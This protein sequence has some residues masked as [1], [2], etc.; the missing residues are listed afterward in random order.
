[1]SGRPASREPGRLEDERHARGG[2]VREQL[3]RTRRAPMWPSPMRLVPVLEGAAHV[4]R[5]VGVDQPQPARAADLD[6]PVDGRGR[7]RRARRAARRRRRRGRCPGRCRPGV[8]VEGGEV[9]LQV[10]DAGA[11]RAALPGGRLQQQP[12]RGVVARPRRAPAAA[13]R[14]PGASRRRTGPSRRRGR[15][16][17]RCARPRPRRR[18]RRRGAG[19]GRPSATDFSYVAAVG[20]AEVHQVRR[21]D[22]H[23]DAALGAGVAGTRA[24]SR[25]SPGR[26]AP[27]RGGCR[28]RP[29]A[30]RSRSRRRV[31]SAPATSPLPTMTWVPTGLR[32]PGRGRVERVTSSGGM[33]EGY[34]RR[35]GADAPGRR[36]MTKRV[37]VLPLGDHRPGPGS[38]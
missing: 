19:C 7:C 29:G 3:A 2:R 6:D 16:T 33:P 31:A 13:P 12:R 24:S 4:H 21:V 10:L 15:R 37:T 34:P 20:R 36:Q 9:R 30:S 27:S 28:R 1:M 17:S 35:V 14:A 22:E 11:Q 5:V 8:V 18:S 38:T 23:P 25:G 26:A 32:R